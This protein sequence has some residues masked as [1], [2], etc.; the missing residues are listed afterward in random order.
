MSRPNIAGP[1]SARGLAAGLADFNFA[2]AVV[3][4]LIFVFGLMDQWIFGLVDFWVD[5]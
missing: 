5:V 2:D 4:L 1:I 3:V